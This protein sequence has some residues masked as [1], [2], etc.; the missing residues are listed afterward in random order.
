MADDVGELLDTLH[1]LERLLRELDWWQESAPPPK[2]LQ[3]NVP[4]HADRLSFH[5][6]L[7]WVFLP[8][9]RKL[10]D[11]GGRLPH[12]CE[13]TP[14]AQVAWRET[15]EKAARLLPLLKR[16]DQLATRLFHRPN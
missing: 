1:Q 4:F 16:I 15:P 10:A 7:Q 5:Q 11:T 9:I 13:T 14:A 12:P 8:A 6:W 2:L 3:S